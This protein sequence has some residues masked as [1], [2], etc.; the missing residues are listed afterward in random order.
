MNTKMLFIPILLSS[1]F[2]CSKPKDIISDYPFKER[3]NDNWGLL[4]AVDGKV[5]IEDE[6][7][8]APTVVTDDCFFVQRAN[9]KYELYNT[10]NIKKVIDDGY[11]DIAAFSNGIAPVVK[12]GKCITV[13]NKDGN[14]LFEL[15]KEYVSLSCFQDGISVFMDSDGKV[16]YIDTKG[17]VVVPAQYAYGTI[18][19]NGLAL[20]KENDRLF[21]INL[22]GEKRPIDDEMAQAWVYM[23]YQ[24]QYWTHQVNDG[25]FSYVTEDDE[26]GI[27]NRKGENIIKASDKYKSIKVTNDG[28]FIFQTEDGYGIMD[29]KGEVIIRDNYDNINYCDENIF[30]AC[31]D[32]KWGELSIKEDEQQLVDFRYEKLH[33]ANSN[34]I[35]YKSN[36]YY[37]L[38]ETGEEIGRYVNLLT[39]IDYFVQSDYFDVVRFVKQILSPKNYNKD[40]TELYGYKG[41]NPETCADELELE[42]HAYDITANMLFPS[43]K[44]FSTDYADVN[45]ILS[46]PEVVAYD[47]DGS[48]HFCNTICDGISLDIDIQSKYTKYMETIQKAF[49]CELINMGYHETES[50]GFI[51]SYEKPSSD[52]KI[53]LISFGNEDNPNRIKI[54]ILTK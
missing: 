14:I 4:S 25:H 11:V 37:L 24:I 39:D 16:G 38:S 13:I 26:W 36:K 51:K 21:E 31:K 29:D 7:K 27:K 28:Y 42:L 50:I 2:S 32:E 30:I 54:N 17:K 41:L 34:F 52:I 23:G 46:F 22:K 10:N 18:F 19:C 9:G 53:Q 15:D 40:V 1:L 12:E 49:E 8:Y 5:L 35:G 20:V 47:Y 33:K 48:A 3:E 44:L 45:A 6:F 43:T